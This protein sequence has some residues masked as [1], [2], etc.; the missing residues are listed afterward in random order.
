MRKAIDELAQQSGLADAGLAEERHELR[1]TVALD[2]PCDGA[3]H[4]ELLVAADERRRETCDAACA[5]LFDRRPRDPRR[6]RLGLALR[7]HVGR[8]LEV[9][10]SARRELRSR[11]D[12]HRPGL[13]VLLQAGGDVDRV[14]ADH[15]VAARGRLAAGDDVPCVDADPK[16]DVGSVTVAHAVG[17]RAEPRLDGKRRADRAL[18]VVVVRLR[19]PEHGQDR[20]THEL[21]GHPA[22]PL[23]LAVDELVELALEIA[24]VLG[25]ELLAE[26][27]GAGEVGEED[28]DDAAL[29][30]I[31]CD[32]GR[33]RVVAERRSAA[34][35][36]RGRG[37]LLGSAAGARAVESRAARAAE[38]RLRGLLGSTV[39]ARDG[40]GSSLRIA[41][42]SLDR[43]DARLPAR[44]LRQ[45]RVRPT[46]S[47]V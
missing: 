18:R 33:L 3:E 45:K 42:E 7:G 2:A 38:P 43:R 37:G 32:R 6:H 36:E 27:C 25:I 23:D 21:L 20:V 1:R 29:L 19:D 8:A 10:R 44:R 15:Q 40:H 26:R 12:E 9:D 46:G 13:R 14:P 11:A 16:P 31:A 41:A 4:V 24:D 5:R 47:L 30:P 34:R 22:V 35:A 17:E 39:G 28:G